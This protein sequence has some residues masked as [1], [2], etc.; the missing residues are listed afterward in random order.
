MDPICTVFA[1]CCISLLRGNMITCQKPCTCIDVT[2]IPRDVTNIVIKSF[3]TTKL[4]ARDYF[5]K[6]PKIFVLDERGETN[7]RSALCVPGMVKAVL[8]GEHP[9]YCSE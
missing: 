9:V 2:D 4:V 8:G 7:D 3:V 6:D 1:L 5:V